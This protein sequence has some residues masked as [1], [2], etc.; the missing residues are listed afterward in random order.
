MYINGHLL[1]VLDNEYKL[2][3]MII[4]TTI[5]EAEELNAFLLKY[6]QTLLAHE[7]K[8][9][10]EIQGLIKVNKNYRY[11][12]TLRIFS[13]YYIYFFLLLKLYSC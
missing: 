12:L 3:T 7:K 10:F 2:K 9:L 1:D 13:A 5:N 4:C 11:I 6:R 8:H